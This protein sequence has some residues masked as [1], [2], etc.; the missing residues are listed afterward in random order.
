MKNLALLLLCLIFS[1]TSCVERIPYAPAAGEE[2]LVID[3]LL[4]NSEA[5]RIIRIKRGSGFNTLNFKGIEA[6][7]QIR[8]N[9]EFWGDLEVVGAGIL[10]VP[11][12]FILE[13]G[14][15]YSVIIETPEGQVIRSRPQTL[16]TPEKADSLTFAVERVVSISEFSGFTTTS[17]FL[18]IY[19]HLDVS[20]RSEPAYLLWHRDGVYTF[21][22]TVPPIRTCY[23]Y[24]PV[25][26]S[27]ITL[28]SSEGLQNQLRQRVASNIIN[29]RL[30]YEHMFNIYMYTIS[31][32]S[33][34][35]YASI[36]RLSELE[37]NLYDEIP[38]PVVGNLTQESGTNANLVGHISFALADTLRIKIRAGDLGV[39]IFNGCLG[40]NPCGP[41]P[42]CPCADCL[43][44]FSGASLEQPEYWND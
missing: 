27:P 41:N 37:G 36:L 42:S 14:N 7:G 23:I 33:Y 34:D 9:D 24:Y 29:S 30:L 10:K 16:Q 31:K 43:S 28:L 20:G 22:E 19:S 15:K 25:P 17:R 3:G 12:Q 2:L 6:S 38:G 5:S 39:D 18:R 26:E 13:P 35:Y 4:S 8:K 32:E 44:S 11:S 40:I 1:I 21:R